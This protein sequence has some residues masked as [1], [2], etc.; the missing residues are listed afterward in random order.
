MHCRWCGQLETH[1]QCQNCGGR[2]PRAGTIGAERTA[3]ELG[4]AFPQVPVISS[5]GDHIK[6]MVGPKPALVVATPGAE[7]VAE[8]GYAA[9]L[10][11]DGN[12]MLA[13]ESLRAAEST[14]RRWFSAA[15]LVRPGPEQGLVVVTAEQEG[16]VGALVRWD[17]AGAALRELELRRG[18]F[19][20]PA[21]RYAA[22]TGSAAGITAFL[23]Q[24][25]LPPGVRTVG[26]APLEPGA[27]ERPRDPA[28]GNTRD[29][30]TEKQRLQNIPGTEPSRAL[31]FFGYADAARVTAALRARKAALS[32]KRTADPVNVHVDD[33]AGL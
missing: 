11:L 2:R 33:V 26:P 28:R 3:E 20:P 25:D 29:R 7:P 1:W 22:L 18:L 5:A 17:P 31:L 24:L 6:S 23:E 19:L 4:R 10:L 12:S 32:A 14:L 15:S 16:T 27:F 9:A 13:R 8:G 30:R 21:V